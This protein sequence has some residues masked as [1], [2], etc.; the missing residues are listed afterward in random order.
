MNLIIP[1]GALI[2][3]IRSAVLNGLDVVATEVE[4]GFS[5]GI[6]GS[7]SSVSPTM[8]SR[9]AA[10]GC[11]WRSATRTSTIPGHEDRDQPVAGRRAQGGVRLD[12]PMAVGIV[13]NRYRMES[14]A[15][16]DLLFYGELNLNGDLNPVKGC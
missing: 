11:G 16:A 13:K 4:V 1:R 3:L 7:S 8:P 2:S 12:L 9:R 14:P 10:S 6:R 5:R 15:F